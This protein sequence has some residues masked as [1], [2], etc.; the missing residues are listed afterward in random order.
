MTEEEKRL[1]ALQSRPAAQL[2]TEAM[3]NMRRVLGDDRVYL[4]MLRHVEGWLIGQRSWLQGIH[5][6]AAPVVPPER[7][8]LPVLDFGEFPG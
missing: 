8:P 3:A 5:P 6:D 4:L 1:F 7:V 2:F